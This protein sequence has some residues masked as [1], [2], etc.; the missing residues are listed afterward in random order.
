MNATVNSRVTGLA[1][2]AAPALLGLYGGIRL[3]AGSRAPGPG[4]TAGHLALLAGLLLFVPV[5][6]ELRRLVA[7]RRPAGR[8]AANLT[9]GL[10]YAGLVAS[11]G[12]TVIDLYVGA[13][14]ADRAEQNQLFDRIQGFPGV[15]P[16]FY[17]VGP[18]LFYLG[19]LAL[20]VTLAA[21][22]ARPVAVWSPVLVLA[23]TV[24]MAADLDFITIGAALWLAALAPSA[25]R[26]GRARPAAAG[27]L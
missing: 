23:G 8:V 6:A 13:R 20:L 11:A 14:A 5:F 27:A 15:L 17:T 18:V 22:R 10:A 7:P 4:W 21:G 3:L 25:R 26:T 12:Q 9:A 2:I 16:V 24:L 19:L 1:W